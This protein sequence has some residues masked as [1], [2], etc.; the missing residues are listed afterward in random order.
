MVIVFYYHLHKYC[1]QSWLHNCD[2]K[3]TIIQI[4]QHNL[5]LVKNDEDD[6]AMCCFKLASLEKDAVLQVFAKITVIN[7]IKIIFQGI[8]CVLV[9]CLS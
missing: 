9:S 2:S 4:F 8:K 7:S 1:T 3:T 6:F 5:A